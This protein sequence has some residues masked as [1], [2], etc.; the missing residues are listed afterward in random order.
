[1]GG[2]GE[3]GEGEGE[4]WGGREEG[5]PCPKGIAPC[6]CEEKGRR[7]MGGKPNGIIGIIIGPE[8]EG[9]WPRLASD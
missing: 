2:L 3:P 5:E 1:M 4:D 6:S 7:P 9:A 8:P